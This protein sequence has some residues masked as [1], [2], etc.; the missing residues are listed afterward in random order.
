MAGKDDVLVKA[1][2]LLARVDDWR[3]FLLGGLDS[4]EAAVLR[5]HE[6]TGRP[7]GERRFVERLERILG[8][9]LRPQAP[10]P[11]RRRSRPE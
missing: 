3:E 7:L 2:P 5:R 11:R 4:D 9:V 8:R 10:G 6:K 1:E